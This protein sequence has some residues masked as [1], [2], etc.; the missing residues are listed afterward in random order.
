MHQHTSDERIL[1]I[2]LPQLC[3]SKSL[4]YER[5]LHTSEE[6][7]QLDIMIEKLLWLLSTTLHMSHEP[8]HVIQSSLNIL[9]YLMRRFEIHTRDHL[10]HAMLLMIWPHHEYHNHSNSNHNNSD[11]DMNINVYHRILKCINVA[12]VHNQSWMFLRPY[13]A[14]HGNS[15]DKNNN[16]PTRMTFAKQCAKQNALLVQACVLAHHVAQLP[17]YSSNS[18]SNSSNDNDKD[19]DNDKDGTGNKNRNCRRGI[20][21]V[22]SFTAA[23]ISEALTLQSKHHSSIQEST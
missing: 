6:N 9:E 10:A 4:Q 21:H 23:L 20:S 8:P 5:H 11:S 1:S 14:S 7:K 16:N 12:Q 13:C 15:D 2:F 22:L 3:S 17:S 18:T 19:Y